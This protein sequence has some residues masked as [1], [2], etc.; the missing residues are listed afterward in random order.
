MEIN[1]WK[2]LERELLI[3]LATSKYIQ[4]RRELE[5]G[6]ILLCKAKEF[7]NLKNSKISATWL[8]KSIKEFENNLRKKEAQFDNIDERIR[9]DNLKE[10][11]ENRVF[12]EE[13]KEARA[14]N[15]VAIILPKPDWT[16]SVKSNLESTCTMQVGFL[17]KNNVIEIRKNLNKN[18]DEFVES[19]VN[20]YLLNIDQYMKEYVKEETGRIES[21]MKNV[22][23]IVGLDIELK[24][25]EKSDISKKL[26]IMGSEKPFSCY[27]YESDLVKLQEWCILGQINKGFKEVCQREQDLYMM[28][29]GTRIKDKISTE[30]KNY[31]GQSAIVMNFSELIMEPLGLIRDYRQDFKASE[32][33]YVRIQR[34]EAYDEEMTSD[35]THDKYEG[36]G[37]AR[38]KLNIRQRTIKFSVDLKVSTIALKNA[39]EI[40]SQVRISDKAQ[41]YF[42][43][44]RKKSIIN[45][46]N[47][48]WDNFS[49]VVRKIPHKTK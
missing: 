8:S 25:D 19:F 9:K 39:M 11:E 21:V 40:V 43:K 44:T 31:S 26:E 23:D 17:E 22:R 3:A 45:K 38:T 34:K 32:G 33:D 24:K 41:V 35:Y 30:L 4:T 1:D 10:P 15:I 29:L 7:R 27:L 49:N 36:F 6:Y 16:K 20:Y 37:S 48:S 12:V 13:K 14:M 2:E 18:E 42:Q 5:N 46:L 47:Q 28:R